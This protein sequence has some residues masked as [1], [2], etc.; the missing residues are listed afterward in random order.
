MFS[1]NSGYYHSNDKWVEY[2]IRD[3]LW[4][5]TYQSIFYLSGPFEP[6][7]TEEHFAPRKFKV[8]DLEH[9]HH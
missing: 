2:M 9:A 7:L 3:D 5:M 1:K 4:A 6:N 8:E